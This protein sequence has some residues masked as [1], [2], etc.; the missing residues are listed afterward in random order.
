MQPSAN[1]K[2]RAALHQSP[3]SGPRDIERRDDLAAGAEANLV[4]QIKSGERVVHQEQRLLQRRA[5]VIGKLDR[6]GAGA[7]FAA[8]DHDEVGRN[9]GL[10]HRLADAEELPRMAEREFEAHR[11]AARKLAQHRNKFD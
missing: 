3:P 9:A 1:M 6:R 8:I 10:E 2:P 7:A 5:D 4:A 11:L